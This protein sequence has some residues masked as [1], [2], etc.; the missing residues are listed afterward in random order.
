M[1]LRTCIFLLN[2][3]YILN[4]LYA[5]SNLVKIISVPLLKIIFIQL[6][7]IYRKILSEE[8]FMSITGIL[9]YT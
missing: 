3:L 8:F 2:N 9:K 6:C 7:I 1:Y 4:E 5:V